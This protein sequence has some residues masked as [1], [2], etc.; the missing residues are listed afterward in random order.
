MPRKV[1][2]KDLFE[3][4]RCLDNG[5]SYSKIVESVGV[6]KGYIAYVVAQLRNS[7]VTPAQAIKLDLDSLQKIVHPQGNN[8]V[9]AD[10]ESV[11]RAL[12]YPSMTMQLQYELY[13][14]Q[15]SSKNVYSYTHFC[16]LYNKWCKENVKP[17]MTANN[18]IVVAEAMEID[19]GGDL[20]EWVD[21]NGELHKCKVFVAC[22]PYS[23]YTYAQLFPDETIN[24]WAQGIIEALA[25]FGGVP[26]TLIM[27]NAKALVRRVN[28]KEGSEV[29]PV[30]ADLCE[31]YGMYPC[32]ARPRHPRDKNR[33]EAA[34]GNIQRR[35]IARLCPESRPVLAKNL[36]A[37]RQIFQKALDEFNDTPWRNK[38]LAGSRKTK[39]ESEERPHLGALPEKPYELTIWHRQKVDKSHC[40]RVGGHRYS[41]P[42]EFTGLQV[43]IRVTER[44]IKIFQV[45]ESK[46]GLIAEHERSYDDTCKTHLLPMHRT[47]TEKAT[48]KS[49]EEIVDEIVADYAVTKREAEIWV[50]GVFSN[51]NIVGRHV[52]RKLRSLGNYNKLWASQALV[53]CV[54]CEIFT[55]RFLKLSF[56]EIEAKHQSELKKTQ[57]TLGNGSDGVDYQTTKHQNIRNDYE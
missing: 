46:C 24:S 51:S 23:E 42:P 35:I 25:Y 29:Q 7:S 10:W 20:L 14:E 37:L 56:E 21:A 27:D 1:R 5:L 40:I 17:K 38:H 13:K 19:F 49:L 31:H 34:V 57:A 53:M 6:S 2:M 22:L 45:A 54:D 55:E 28:V 16:A 3:V 8:R 30:I 47:A 52:V 4:V 36:K 11:H 12:Q 32:P 9:Q 44:D 41:V 48:R 15:Q 50:Q 26:K 18:E 39:Y 43:D 33:V